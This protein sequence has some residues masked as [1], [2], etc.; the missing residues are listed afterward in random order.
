MTKK[1]GHTYCG[2]TNL[3]Q[4]ATEFYCQKHGTFR[5]VNMN[6]IMN[7]IKK[8]GDAHAESLEVIRDLMDGLE[9]VLASLPYP[10]AWINQDMKRIQH[11]RDS[12]RRAEAH[13]RK[14][15]G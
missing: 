1:E 5:M 13:I 11:G 4:I 15:E 7:G 10:L 3:R 12:Y 2:C 14:M 8:S 9:D 6:S